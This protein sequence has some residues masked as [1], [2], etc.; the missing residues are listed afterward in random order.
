MSEAK[1]RT[2]KLIKKLTRINMCEKIKTNHEHEINELSWLHFD[3]FGLSFF[4]AFTNILLNGHPGQGVCI[5]VRSSWTVLNGEVKIRK[6]CFPAV[7]CSIE[8]G[9]GKYV[10]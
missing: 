10:G 9:G 8:P 4:L 6:F 1:Q 2:N 3:P 7:T 5:L